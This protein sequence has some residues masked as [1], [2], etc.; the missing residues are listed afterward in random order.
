M[1]HHPADGAVRRARWG[2]Y[3]A[4]A[5][6]VATRMVRAPSRAGG[7]LG[8]VRRAA[9]WLWIWAVTVLTLAGYGAFTLPGRKAVA[10]AWVL[11]DSWHG[12]VR[13]L[14]VLAA[15]AACVAAILLPAPMWLAV[16][17]AS[18]V[19]VGFAANLRRARRLA[20]LRRC[21]PPGAL[22]VANIASGEPGAGK[23]VLGQVCRWADDEGRHVCLE[24]D[25]HPKLVAY[26]GQHGFEVGGAVRVGPRTTVYMERKPQ[27]PLLGGGR[28]AGSDT[29]VAT[30]GAGP[31]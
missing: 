25:A 8:S 21:R 15:I 12:L 20:P 30:G 19:V 24:A 13:A 26:Y 27:S 14:P 17:F 6:L 23:E 29:G 5:A 3:P 31:G 9:A 7:R 16:G 4:L 18:A 2:E 11:E 22:L 1:K 10:S 28:Q